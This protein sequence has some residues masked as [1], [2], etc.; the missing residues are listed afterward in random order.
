MPEDKKGGPSLRTLFWIAA[1]GSLL[2][3]LVPAAGE[4]AH[5]GGQFSGLVVVMLLLI[6]AVLAVVA[7]A[8]GITRKPL[9][10][11]IGLAVMSVP[12]LW[13]AVASVNNLAL[14]LTPSLPAPSQ[15][16]QAAGRGYFTAPADG[17]LAE[18]I[19]AKDAARVAELAPA[20]NLAATGWGNMDFMRLA[21]ERTDN[22]PEIIGILLRAGLNPDLAAG[23]LYYNIM[24][25]KDEVL[26]RR[27]IEAGVDLNRPMRQ[28]QWYLFVR[29]DWPE[30]VAFMLD[31]GFNAET[32]DT[33]GYTAIM[34]AAQVRNWPAVEV[35][36]A[37]GART[38]QVSNDGRSLRD[39]L[40][41]ATA[42]LNSAIPPGI[43]ALQASLR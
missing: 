18:A 3:V 29:N 6:A 40:S 19:V 8:V 41:E 20:A 10:Y 1:C 14:S 15:A 22:D 43:T 2:L 16:D 24:S 35:L 13:V 12:L 38:D 4:M 36:L 33:S 25:A 11:G 17:A 27:V 5:P 34:K 26:L 32:R 7:T 39:L 31:H 42:G 28:A 9:A 37:H 23:L 21:L 30:G